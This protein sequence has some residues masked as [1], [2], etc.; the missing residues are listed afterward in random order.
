ML[1]F[2]MTWQLNSKMVTCELEVAQNWH[3]CNALLR[4][5]MRASFIGVREEYASGIGSI[6]EPIEMDCLL[7][8]LPIRCHG[9]AHQWLPQHERRVA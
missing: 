1:H 4:S 2:D 8:L 9:P 3:V 5:S 7:C 6:H